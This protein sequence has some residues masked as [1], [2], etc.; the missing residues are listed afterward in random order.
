[1]LNDALSHDLPEDTRHY[2]T[3]VRKVSSQMGTLIDGLLNISRTG[4]LIPEKSVFNMGHLVRDVIEKIGPDLQNREIAWTIQPL[5]DVFGD[6]TLLRQVWV[7]LVGNAVKYTRNR[8]VAEIS[9]GFRDEDG[10]VVFFIRD[11]GVGFDMKYVNKLFTV[12][13][14]LHSQNEFE[15]TGIGLANVQRIIRKHNGD[16]WA[17]GEPGAGAVFYFS[18][19]K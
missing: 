14:R 15:G 7:N 16:V 8:P 5:P 13:Q 9:I 4:Q 17:E 2:L 10:L 6:V 18:L 1:M 12:F 11:N 19:P 3:T